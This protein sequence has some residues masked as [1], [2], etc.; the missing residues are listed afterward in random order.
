M[1]PTSLLSD[2]RIAP[3][4]DNLPMGSTSRKVPIRFAGSS[5]ER[6]GTCLAAHGLDEDDDW[7]CGDLADVPQNEPNRL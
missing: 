1:M 6:W 7:A 5:V 2:H 4:D 3:A